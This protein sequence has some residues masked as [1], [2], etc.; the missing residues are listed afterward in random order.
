MTK[1]DYMKFPKDRLAELL[2]QKDLED[3]FAG[4]IY[5]GW[6]PSIPT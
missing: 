4:G 3:E 6:V 5:C 2:A 1:E